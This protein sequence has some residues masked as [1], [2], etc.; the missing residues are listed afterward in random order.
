MVD[1]SIKGLSNSMVKKIFV[2]KLVAMLLHFM[3]YTLTAQEVIYFNN[4][5]FESEPFAGRLDIPEF[6]TKLKE[7]DYCKQF[8]P[9]ETSPD[10]HSKTSNYWGV[11]TTPSDGN[12]CLGMVARSNGAW[13]CVSQILSAPIQAKT[14]YHF[15][16]DLCISMQFESMV[17]GSLSNLKFDTPLV[18]RVWG[19][20]KKCEMQEKLFVSPTISNS[21]WK[22]Y[23]VL[24]EPSKEFKYIIFQAFYDVPVLEPYNGNLLMDNLSEVVV[25]QD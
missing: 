14:K 21:H 25:V 4:P 10:L 22:T 23:D 9:N 2:V 17:I 5:S 19:S 8:F 15:T 6:E 18:L 12:T 20:N 11:E 16:I 3:S 13:E 7:W 1:T 24:I